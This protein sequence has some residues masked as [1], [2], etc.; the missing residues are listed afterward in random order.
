MSRQRTLDQE[1]AQAAWNCVK[2][3]KEKAFQAKYLQLSRGATADIQAHGLAQTLAFWRAKKEDQHQTLLKDITGW[4][5]KR[6]G[7]TEPDLLNWITAETTR[8]SD[9]RRATVE[10]LAFLTWVKRFAE[11]ELKEA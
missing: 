10:V 4:T 9:Y 7:L 1:R 6:L 3:V 11:A 8:T 5:T 2:E